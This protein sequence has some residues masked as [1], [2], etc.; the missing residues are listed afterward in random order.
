MGLRGI[1]ILESSGDTGV[2][3]GCQTNNGTNLPTYDPQFP[4][5]C[6]YITAVGGTQNLPEVAWDASSGGFSNYFARPWYQD[7]AVNEYLTSRIGQ[8]TKDNV[9]PYTNFSGRGFPDISAH[10]EKPR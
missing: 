9:S 2:G 10:S 5:T 1:S 3:A 7:T 6:P 8:A 4:G